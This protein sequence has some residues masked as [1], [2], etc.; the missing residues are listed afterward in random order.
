MKENIPNWFD[1]D[2]LYKEIAK[3]IPNGSTF[4]ELGSW[5]GHSISFFAQQIKLLK[6]NVRIVTIDNFVGSNEEVHKRWA[7]EF[8]GSFRALY[9]NTLKEAGVS[10]MV[11]TITG[12]SADSAQLFEDNS[13]QVL[14]ID[15]DHTT[16]SVV[17]DI[18]AWKPKIT[19]SGTIAGHDI[20]WPPVAD[21]VRMFGPYLAYHH[22]W[23]AQGWDK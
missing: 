2:W 20:N 21:A 15:A 12:D 18:K 8:G 13:V 4:V 16:A 17:R 14:F 10:D 5:V 1:Y 9:D 3:Q 19:E 22:C 6:K 11:E 7:A 23:I